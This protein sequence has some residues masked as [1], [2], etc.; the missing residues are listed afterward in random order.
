MRLLNFGKVRLNLNYEIALL[1]PLFPLFGIKKS[2]IIYI[3]FFS[4]PTLI[5]ECECL[6][7]TFLYKVEK[8]LFRLSGHHD[9]LQKLT[10]PFVSF[11]TCKMNSV[12][13]AMSYKDIKNKMCK[14]GLNSI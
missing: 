8:Y 4:L 9:I 1:Y 3:A 6:H 7:K 12:S 14:T 13:A 2:L 11:V 5:G 10:S